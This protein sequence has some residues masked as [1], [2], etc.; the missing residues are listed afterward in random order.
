MR[1][2]PL[3]RHEP[4]RR[5]LLIGALA[6]TFGAPVP[7]VAAGA[8]RVIVVGA[9][10]SGLAAARHLAD[11][12]CAVIVLEA[13]DRTGGRLHTDRSLGAPV[14]MGANWIH[15]IER[16]P[17]TALAKS[18]GAKTL[19]TDSDDLMEIFRPGGKPVPDREL[20]AAEARYARVLQKIDDEI[21]RDADLSLR[22]ALEARDPAIFR[23]PLLGFVM[24]DETES[25]IGAPADGI[26]AY[27]FDEDAAFD[28]P[29]VILPDGYDAILAPL[30]RGLDIRLG[31]PVTRLIR[32]TAGVK[33]ET[34]GGMLEAD[35]AICSVPLGA[36]KAGRVAFDPPLPAAHRTAIERIG[37]GTVTRASIAFS[38]AFWPKT[39][40]FFG[41]V[42]ATRGRWPLVLNHK[43]LTGRNILTAIA[44]GPYAATVDGM[45][46]DAAKADLL[47]ALADLFGRQPPQSTGFVVSNWSRDPFAGGAY[48]VVAPGS[49]PDDFTAL[50]AGIDGRLFLTGEHTDFAYHATVHGA[51]L[52]GQRTAKA[53]V[54]LAAGR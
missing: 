38:E 6:A 13:R 9:G 22:A 36:L 11:A 4:S 35:F 43:A 18:V 53:I 33:A 16:N 8:P 28:G 34:A 15:G 3:R 5:A 40:H 54:A 52:S 7:V 29:E 50:A 48:S 44:T 31:T 14:E 25:D 49:T 17:I 2:K 27:W 42:A 21:T 19:V 51:F 37:V 30:A 39:P 10:V 12:G 24:T 41:H 20:D 45:T 32:H 26:S 23:D 1:Q 47:A 46:P